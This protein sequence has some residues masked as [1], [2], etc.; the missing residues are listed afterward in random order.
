MT[1]VKGTAGGNVPYVNT[2]SVGVTV[3]EPAGI[4]A[5]RFVLVATTN[6]PV[7][8]VAVS[9]IVVGGTV[10]GESVA[11]NVKVGGRDVSV[12]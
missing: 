11:S 8:A 10:V 5:G 7:A 9:E 12:G 3:P 4:D 1:V 6:V 2:P